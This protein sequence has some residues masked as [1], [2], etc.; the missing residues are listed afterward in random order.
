MSKLTKFNSGGKDYFVMR[1]NKVV[2]VFNYNFDNNSFE[3]LYTWNLPDLP[4]NARFNY[5]DHKGENIYFTFPHHQ[6]TYENL[7]VYNLKTLKLAVLM[8][9]HTGRV[10]GCAHLND[11]IMLT[12]STAGELKAW[13]R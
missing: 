8:N 5:Y 11:D 2:N 1:N 9:S 6:T 4:D 12:T 10:T 7:G 13:R 3:D